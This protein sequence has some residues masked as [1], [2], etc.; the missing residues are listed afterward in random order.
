MGL[1]QVTSLLAV[2]H[3]ETA[4]NRETRIQGQLDTP[5]S[6]LGAAQARR[7]AQALDGQGVDVIY[8]SDL[9]RARQTAEAVAQQLGLAVQLEPGLRERGFGL[10]EGLTWAE[11]ETRWPAESERWRR[12][13]PQF[14]AQGGESLQDFYARAVAAVEA[15]ASRHPG[16]TVLIVAHGGVLDC[17]YRAAARQSL[18]AARTWTLGNASINRLLYSQSGLTLVGWND[19]NHL[20]GLSLDDTAA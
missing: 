19:D 2:R 10:F 16:Q 8:A 1:D 3:G 15:L 14:A 11:I 20:A 9:A 5:L 17:L 12:R 7:L 4:W 6:P 13:D 18:Q